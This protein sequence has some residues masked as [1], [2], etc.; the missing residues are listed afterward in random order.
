MTW[1]L[2][3]LDG[4]ID[5][6]IDGLKRRTTTIVHDCLF[7]D[8][9]DAMSFLGGP[10]LLPD[11]QT[12]SWV[13]HCQKNGHQNMAINYLGALLGGLLVLQFL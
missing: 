5:W 11:Y 1:S 8:A 13:L 9:L 3:D 4:E 7:V 6:I 10:K 2:L 12:I